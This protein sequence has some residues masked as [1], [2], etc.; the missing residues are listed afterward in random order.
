MTRHSSAAQSV[1]SAVHTRLL[2][3]RQVVED[4]LDLINR[5]GRVRDAFERHVG[6]E[7]IQ[8]SPGVAN[9]REAA[10][11]LLTGFVSSPGFAP[12]VKRIVSDHDVVV[13]FMHLVIDSHPGGLAVVDIW[14]LNDSKIV[15]H[16]DVVQAVPSTSAN[17]NS[18]F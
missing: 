1:A 3:N 15:E 18:M 8:H 7:Y 14:R 9:G 10:I 2:T 4:F 13:T 11:E 12:V 16:W 17:G 6:E 5:E